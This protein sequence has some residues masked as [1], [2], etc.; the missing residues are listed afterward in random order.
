MRAVPGG[1]KFVIANHNGRDPAPGPCPNPRG[2]Y[3]S[4]AGIC[5]TPEGLVA[6]YRLS[7]SHTALF[8]HV[9]TARSGDGGRTWDGHR[10]IAHRN[11]WEHQACWVAPQLS[12]LRDGRLVVLVDEGRRS[13]G[14]EW[15]LLTR[16]QRRPERG[17]A[18]YLLWSSD[19]GRTWSAPQQVDEV[20]GEPGYVIELADGTLLYTRTESAVYPAM[21]DPPGRW[22]AGYYRNVAVG[23]TDGGRSWQ[24]VGT[25]TDAPYHG[26]CEVGMAELEQ[27]GHLLAMTRIGFGG[28]AFGQP[29]RLVRSYDGGRT[30]SAPTL[31]PVYGQRTMLHRLQS[32]KLLVTYRN[33]WG[34]PCSRA[35]LFHPEEELGFEPASFIW[36]DQRC[37]RAGGEMV[38]VT[39][40]GRTAEVEFSL[41]PAITGAAEVDLELEL[42]RAPGPG[43]VLLCAGFGVSIGD[44][45]LE[46]ARHGGEPADAGSQCGAACLDTAQWHTYRLERRPGGCRVLV[47]GRQVLAGADA[48]LRQREVRFG[49][50]GEL[51]TRWRAGNAR[52]YNPGDY[53]VDWRWHAGDGFPDQFQRDR[54]VVLDYTSDSGYSAWTQLADGTIVIADY[55]S[56]HFENINA[57]GPQPILKAYRVREEELE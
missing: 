5:D 55:T 15:G 30:W 52:V 46:F 22:G 39:G 6:T 32:G 26:D 25:V 11:V 48:G 44:G 23:S 17:M 29:S 57:G 33:R 16:W 3:H 34:T 14:Q 28:G 41:Y 42:R 56:D 35:F 38:T 4:V 20:G 40:A 10:S 18:N 24:P 50:A 9:M 36:E 49:A 47:D 1:C 51:E 13:S 12:R 54:T 53:S 43:R 21:D 8:T 19:H 45:R 37:T 31:T 2:W 7:D 27:P